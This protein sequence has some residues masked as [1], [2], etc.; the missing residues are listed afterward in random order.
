MKKK[1][2]LALFFTL[3]SMR[4]F[5]DYVGDYCNYNGVYNKPSISKEEE[6]AMLLERM[7]S[8]NFK[9]ITKAMAAVASTPQEELNTLACP[10]SKYA[11]QLLEYY[12]KNEQKILENKE[13]QFLTDIINCIKR[14]IKIDQ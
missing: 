9:E 14:K 11:K 8:P 1:L 12:Q 2:L 6:F 5:A 4:S 13:K 10:I 7:E 3:F